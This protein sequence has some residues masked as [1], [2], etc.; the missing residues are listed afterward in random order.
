VSTEK[1]EHKSYDSHK[2]QFYAYSTDGAQADY[3]KSWLNGETADAW[4]HQRI[5]QS[6]E[7]L[8]EKDRNSSWL[9]VGDGRYGLDAQFLASKGCN[10][11]ASDISDTLLKEAASQNL[12]NSYSEE[13]AE[14]LSF[15]DEQFDYIFCKDAYHHFP[16]PIKALYEMLRVAKKG[17]ILI[18]P[19]DHLLHGKVLDFFS[20]NIKKLHSKILGSVPDISRDYEVSGNYVYRVSKREFEKVAMGLNYPAIAF[21]GVNDY[22]HEKMLDELV[23]ENGPYYRRAKLAIKLLD[24]LS[25]LKLRDYRLITVVMFKDINCNVQLERLESAGFEVVHLSR[26][27]YI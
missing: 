7:P 9:T 13:N 18:E 4:R 21:K 20:Y 6:V 11:T 26:N 24:I 15:K 2:S 10:V 3:A 25:K 23:V 12:I 17:V 8:I 19:S 14:S 27:P 16:R 1:F 22:Y 5:Y